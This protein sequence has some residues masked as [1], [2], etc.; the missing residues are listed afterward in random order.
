MDDLKKYYKEQAESQPEPSI[1]FKTAE[2][3]KRRPM[4]V[5]VLLAAVAVVISM[6]ALA[7]AAGAFKTMS[8]NIMTGKSMEVTIIRNDAAFDAMYEIAVKYSAGAKYI[9]VKSESDP[10]LGM[11][12][13]DNRRAFSDPDSFYEAARNTVF[14]VLPPEV[15]P[16]NGTFTGSFV[17]DNRFAT[18]VN[19][20]H[21]DGYLITEY[22][23][24]ETCAVSMYYSMNIEHG[25][26]EVW[27][28]LINGE[29][30]IQP[31]ST[32]VK[33]VS[34]SGWDNALTG[35]Q[36]DNGETWLAISK[37]VPQFQ[38][39]DGS[40][41]SFVTCVLSSATLS[42]DELIEFAEQMK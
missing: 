12:T 42:V 2:R 40:A 21:E 16:K 27:V 35:V 28:P 29:S 18:K 39:P 15:I 19:E 1:I 13:L 38:L 20:W 26:L 4:R 10:S 11:V 24:D 30:V 14:P 25:R 36:S 33:T 22:K 34:I 23:T 7:V 9:V 41:H 32:G 31:E 5:T 6:T 37:E 17:Y 3:A 8:Y